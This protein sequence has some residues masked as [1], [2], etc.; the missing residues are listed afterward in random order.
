MPE[1]VFAGRSNVGK[2]SVIRQLTGKKIDVGKRPGVTREIKRYELGKK[3]DLVD[4]PGFGFISGMSE[5]KQEKIKTQIIQYL[6]D[7]AEEILFAIEIIDS[8]SFSEIIERWE[9]RGQ[10]PIAIELF[11]FLKELN[12]LPI[13][14]A[15]KI[16]LIY[17]E[18]RDE[19][20]DVI[21]EKL[22]L[23]PPWRQWMD[24]IVPVS[25]KTGEGINDLKKL[26]RER[27]QEIN[28]EQLL[29]YAP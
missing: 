23:D 17:S 21:C 1:I 12:L 18:D 26:I 3:L 29:R 8:R 13:V 6:E 28:Q 9:S 4:L 7:N 20:L 10:I 11:N 2:S 5:K 25:A 19:V 14:V 27:M 22:G 15:N 16:D 24:T